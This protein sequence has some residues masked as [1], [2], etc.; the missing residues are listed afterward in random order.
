MANY[1][2]DVLASGICPSCD[3][4]AAW[5]IEEQYSYGVY[6]GVMCRDCAMRYRDQCGHGPTGQGDPADLDE[7]LDPDE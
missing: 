3:T 1:L 7:P 4:P 6:A 5:A 2:R